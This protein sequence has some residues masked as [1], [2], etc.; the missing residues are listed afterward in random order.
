MGPA[1]RRSALRAN[2]RLARA[3]GTAQVEEG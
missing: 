3:E 1:P 2:R